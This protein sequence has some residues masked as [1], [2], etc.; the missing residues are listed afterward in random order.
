M[1]EG[2]IKNDNDMFMEDECVVCIRN[3]GGKLV[4]IFIMAG[5]LVCVVAVVL[6]RM[7]LFRECSFSVIEVEYLVVG[8]GVV[9]DDIFNLGGNLVAVVVELRWRIYSWW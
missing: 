5:I 2:E 7:E 1:D 6:V 8:F 3:L 9:G 4:L